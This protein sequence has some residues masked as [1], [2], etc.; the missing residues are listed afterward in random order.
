MAKCVLY[1]TVIEPEITKTKRLTRKQHT[2]IKKNGAD[3]I[4]T[5]DFCI[6]HNHDL[7]YMANHRES[8]ESIYKEHFCVKHKTTQVCAIYSIPVK[9]SDPSKHFVESCQCP[10]QRDQSKLNIAESKFFL[11]FHHISHF[12]LQ[13]SVLSIINLVSDWGNALN[14]INFL[15]PRGKCASYFALIAI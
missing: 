14:F 4:K 2:F 12:N 11:I 6:S 1:P 13:S 15:K 5:L 9:H 10:P 8:K 3:S 7:F